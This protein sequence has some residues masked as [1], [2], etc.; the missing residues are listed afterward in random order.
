[1]QVITSNREEDL[2]F[3]AVAQGQFLA[4]V[5]LDG[6]VEQQLILTLKNNMRRNI[7]TDGVVALMYHEAGLKHG[8]ERRL[9][10]RTTADVCLLR[11]GMRSL[12]SKRLKRIMHKP[13]EYFSSIG[14]A[15]LQYLAYDL[16]RNQD[17]AVIYKKMFK[18]FFE[19]A[20]VL[21]I[22]EKR[23]M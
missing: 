6:Q 17:V 18:Q 2:W 21:R 13:E 12:V 14:I 16:R 22:M 9:A 4:R 15:C 20:K 11:T 8:A 10:L 3:S 7:I 23:K 1:M 19:M 5:T